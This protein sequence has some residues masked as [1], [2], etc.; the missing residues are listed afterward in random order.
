MPQEFQKYYGFTKFAVELNEIE[1]G[2]ESLLPR[3]DTRLRPDQR[4]RH[5]TLLATLFLSSLEPH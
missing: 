5:D 4:Y 3:T 1:P 2:H